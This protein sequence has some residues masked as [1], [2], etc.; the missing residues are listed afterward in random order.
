MVWFS[1]V[2]FGNIRFG[3]AGIV[4]RG[5]V[6]FG[7]VQYCRFSIVRQDVVRSGCA[8]VVVLC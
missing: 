7:M 8:V 2:L 6:R 3:V 1:P 5:K 4:L